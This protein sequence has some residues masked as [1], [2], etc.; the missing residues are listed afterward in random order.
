MDE[1]VIS[2]LG[3]HV[4][5]LEEGQAWTDLVTVT[6]Q[7][8]EANMLAVLIRQYV[9]DAKSTIQRARHAGASSNPDLLERLAA[10]VAA[11]KLNES[12]RM[13]LRA[14]GAIGEV[15]APEPERTEIAAAL[16]G[17]RATDAERAK[18]AEPVEAALHDAYHEATGTKHED[19]KSGLN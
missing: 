19:D 1:T 3:V 6:F 15:I 16:A 17:A 18:S 5:E 8:D 7:R 14:S 9:D 10:T 2:G 12:L 4:V 13:V 11:V